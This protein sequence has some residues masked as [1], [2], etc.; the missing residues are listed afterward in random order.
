MAQ[1]L[2]DDTRDLIKTDSD[3]FNK[4]SKELDLLPGSL[5]TALRRNSATL[6]HY[7]VVQ[8]IVKHTGKKATELLTPANSNTLC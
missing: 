8:I 1:K 6:A 5:L 2:T 4:I 7:D 3:L